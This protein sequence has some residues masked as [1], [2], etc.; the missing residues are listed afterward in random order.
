MG[1]SEAKLAM[2][3]LELAVLVLELSFVLFLPQF[4][5][6]LLERVGVVQVKELPQHQALRPKEL[7]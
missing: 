7:G 1:R 6:R 5:L 3:L 2:P 4:Q